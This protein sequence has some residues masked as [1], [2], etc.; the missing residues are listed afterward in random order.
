MSGEL[1][2]IP[3]YDSNFDST[4]LSFENEKISG[5]CTLDLI[6]AQLITYLGT[7]VFGF[8]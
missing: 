4:L 3:T 6:Y 8:S 5:I 1:A 7:F 2:F